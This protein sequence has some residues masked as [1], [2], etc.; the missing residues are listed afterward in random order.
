LPAAARLKTT[1]GHDGEGTEH[2][3]RRAH[4]TRRAGLSTTAR[5]DGWGGGC[6]SAAR[7]LDG[8]KGAGRLQFGRGTGRR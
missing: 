6:A 5:V 1:V 7:A 4:G 2:A 3:A 8:C